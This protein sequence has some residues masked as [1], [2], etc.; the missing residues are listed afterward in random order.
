MNDV[1]SGSSLEGTWYMLA[2]RKSLLAGDFRL[3]PRSLR[4]TVVTFHS[5]SSGLY[6]SMVFSAA[7]VIKYAFLERLSSLFPDTT[8][9]VPMDLQSLGPRSGYAFPAHSKNMSFFAR[10]MYWLLYKRLFASG[11][12]NFF[13]LGTYL[14]KSGNK[15][16]VCSSAPK[17]KDS[18]LVWL[19]TTSDPTT[20]SEQEKECYQKAYI[21]FT[22]FVSPENIE[23]P[24][25]EHFIGE[26]E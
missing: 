2:R 24:W 5:D 21:E 20:A 22:K 10:L 3:A 4:R 25:N 15:Y 11:R 17:P 18:I 13:I 8:Y 16:I 19:C 26:P 1:F 6:W 12:A 23:F 7:M 14:S 9:S